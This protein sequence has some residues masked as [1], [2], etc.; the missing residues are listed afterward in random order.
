MFKVDQRIRS[1]SILIEEGRLSTVF[2]KNVQEF[3]W[4]VL[5]PRVAAV[6]EIYELSRNAQAQLIEEIA[7]WSVVLKTLF[8]I[9][10]MNIGAL[11]SRSRRVLF[12]GVGGPEEDPLWPDGIWQHPLQTTVYPPQVLENILESFSSIKNQR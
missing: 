5:V 10:K 8:P 1:T 6:S 3:P 12:M 4:L 11:G 2:L 7:D 9:Q